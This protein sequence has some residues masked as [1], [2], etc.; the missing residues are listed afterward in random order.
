[1]SIHSLATLLLFLSSPPADRST[2]YTPLLMRPRRAADEKRFALL[3]AG[4]S[5]LPHSSGLLRRT[6]A[7]AA[8][9][10]LAPFC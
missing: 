5:G 4:R 1:V 6:A 8:S 2:Y 9:R 7:R 3:S 10:R